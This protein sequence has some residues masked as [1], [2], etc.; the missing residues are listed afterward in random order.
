[1]DL[2]LISNGLLWDHGCG[3][4]ALLCCRLLLTYWPLSGFCLGP[5]CAACNV[6]FLN[7]VDTESL[8][9]PQAIAKAIKMTLETQVIAKTTVVHFK[10]SSQG[11]TLTDNMRKWASLGLMFVSYMVS[12]WE[13]HTKETLY[14]EWIVCVCVWMCVFVCVWMCV[15]VCVCVCTRTC[16]CWYIFVHM[17]KMLICLYLWHVHTW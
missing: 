2:V 14:S 11:V 1:M 4:N 13:K 8:T 6:I 12:L 17:Y 5:V 3:F 16:A 10:V 9:G 15:F 7:T